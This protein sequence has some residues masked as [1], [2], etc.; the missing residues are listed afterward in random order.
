ME[1]CKHLSM[2]PVFS[3]LPSQYR[4]MLLWRVLWHFFC[5]KICIELCVL[6]IEASFSLFLILLACG[7]IRAGRQAVVA[8]GQHLV[9]HRDKVPDE[10]VLVNGVLP[11]VPG[12]WV[13]SGGQGEALQVALGVC[14]DPVQYCN[15][16]CELFVYYSNAI[17]KTLQKVKSKKYFYTFLKTGIFSIQF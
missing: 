10:P 13:V 14:L 3:Y 11:H 16:I 17:Q 2:E 7:L 4:Q 15:G 6:K 9:E 1:A 8:I 12:G 5:W